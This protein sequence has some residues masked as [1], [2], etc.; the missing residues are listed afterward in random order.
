V[1]LEAVQSKAPAVTLQG[2]DDRAVEIAEHWRDRATVL[3]FLRHF[4]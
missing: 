3:V 2:E 1:P 4:G